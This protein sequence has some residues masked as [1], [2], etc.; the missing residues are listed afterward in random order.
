MGPYTGHVNEWQKDTA[1]P[2]HDTRLR[3]RRRRFHTAT[4]PNLLKTCQKLCSGFESDLLY[5]RRASEKCLVLAFAALLWVR[6]RF[7]TAAGGQEAFDFLGPT[8]VLAKHPASQMSRI[9][10]CKR[11]RSRDLRNLQRL[12]RH[13][14]RCG[15]CTYH[16]NRVVPRSAYRLNICYTFAY[17]HPSSIKCGATPH[18]SGKNEE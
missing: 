11:S 1:V 15:P 10:I 13:P 16:F 7:T 8:T 17:P 14:L 3:Q 2:A 9:S 4:H 12:Q 18:L 6:P 5:C